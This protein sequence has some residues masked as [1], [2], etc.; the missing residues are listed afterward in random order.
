MAAAGGARARARTRREPRERPAAASTE[1][2]ERGAPTDSGRMPPPVVAAE[3][4]MGEEAPVLTA[5]DF[6]SAEAAS[7][8][9]LAILRATWAAEKEPQREGA[10]AAE[11]EP[12]REGAAADTDPAATTASAAPE[13]FLCTCHL[14]TSAT[15]ANAK[16][17]Q[18]SCPMEAHQRATPNPTVD[19]LHAWLLKQRREDKFKSKSTSKDA[20]QGIRVSEIPI[21]DLLQVLDAEVQCGPCRVSIRAAIFALPSAPVGMGAYKLGGEMLPV[22]L[23][24]RLGERRVVVWLG[25]PPA[26]AFVV[27]TSVPPSALA[28]REL[29]VLGGST[30]APDVFAPVEF[31]LSAKAQEDFR[32]HVPMV[33]P[34]ELLA[35]LGNT[36]GKQPTLSDHALRAVG[37][38]LEALDKLMARTQEGADA[39]ERVRVRVEGLVRACAAAERG[40]DVLRVGSYVCML[41]GVQSGSGRPAV[42]F[43]VA[44]A[45]ATRALDAS[46]TLLGVV[47]EEL[48]AYAL[49]AM[50]FEAR[51]TADEAASF[52][53]AGLSWRLSKWRHAALNVRAVAA[54]AREALGVCRDVLSQPE[55]RALYE[56]GEPFASSVR[57]SICSKSVAE[58]GAAD[59]KQLKCPGGKLPGVE[60]VF[61]EFYAP[62]DDDHVKAGNKTSVLRLFGGLGDDGRTFHPALSPMEALTTLMETG[63]VL[64]IGVASRI[65]KTDELTESGFRPLGKAEGGV[66][67]EAWYGHKQFTTIKAFK[68]AVERGAEVF[69]ERAKGARGAGASPGS[70]WLPSSPNEKLA[71]AVG[72]LSM[73]NVDRC[74]QHFWEWHVSKQRLDDLAAV[75]VSLN[76]D[77]EAL[78]MIV[79]SVRAAMGY[80]PL[81]WLLG[82][83]WRIGR[84]PECS[85]DPRP[86]AK[87][88]AAVRAGLPKSFASTAVWSNAGDSAG[89]VF[90]HVLRP[91]VARE[92]KKEEEAKRA[93]EAEEM[94]Q[95]SRVALEHQRALD[96]AQRAEEQQQRER[97]RKRKEEQ[98]KV[99]VEKARKEKEVREAN[100]ARKRAEEQAREEQERRKAAEERA[101]REEVERAQ[102]E[103][104]EQLR[105]QKEE[106]ARKDREERAAA[107]AARKKEAAASRGSGGGGT[108]KIKREIQLPGG[109]E[110][111][112]R[113]KGPRGE[114]VQRLETLVGASVSFEVHPKTNELSATLTGLED[115]VEAAERV[116]RR[117]SSMRKSVRPDELLPYVQDA[118]MGTALEETV[119]AASAA[120][121]ARAAAKR[122]ATAGRAFAEPVIEA[123]VPPPS[124]YDYEYAYEDEDVSV[125]DGVRGLSNARGENSCFLNVV[126]QSL[127]HIP[128]FS[129]RFTAEA[130]T[131]HVCLPRGPDAVAAIEAR[132]DLSEVQKAVAKR[133]AEAPC[134]TCTVTNTFQA[135][136][137]EGNAAVVSSVGLRAAVAAAFNGAFEMGQM[138]DAAEAFK[139]LLE[140]V[141]EELMLT[142][143]EGAEGVAL[144]R[145]VGKGTGAEGEHVLEDEPDVRCTCSVHAGLSSV[146]LKGARCYSCMALLEAYPW[147]A[148]TKPAK[149]PKFFPV[150]DAATVEAYR[151]VA[152]RHGIVQIRPRWTEL[153]RYVFAVEMNT[154]HGAEFQ[155]RVRRCSAV[156]P[157]SCP[158][159]DEAGFEVEVVLT[160][161]PDVMVLG[162]VWPSNRPNLDLEVR[163]FV[164][165]VSTRINLAHVAMIR[166]DTDTREAPPLCDVLMADLVG[167]ITF[168]HEHYI[169]FARRDGTTNSWLEFNDAS[170]RNVGSWGDV[171]RRM[172]SVPHGLQPVVLLYETASASASASGASG[173]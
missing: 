154:M 75:R 169:A 165:S 66:V 94:A 41:T 131:R 104:A 64:A 148:A 158:L 38:H 33:F 151:T 42:D 171:K 95:Q 45:T 129:R 70:V 17:T 111:S 54:A 3:G 26:A 86:G 6:A 36:S 46:A 173:A 139:E 58:L 128:S 132:T 79:P 116:L 49:Q 56:M 107:E 133:R 2:S 124:A 106:Q 67:G 82:L 112:G 135:L 120:A 118:V 126:T 48:K 119:A 172:C 130:K 102:R 138:E 51:E 168:W 59:T 144:V 152:R 143:G 72:L 44:A 32:A 1:A 141:H 153:M 145:G 142:R 39:S 162:V 7:A 20:K 113:L 149:V 73:E 69:A 78:D 125:V 127:Y 14:N 101:K 89:A 83:K 155:E 5:G 108:V 60:S 85:V 91:L 30:L 77:A 103:V 65:K 99:E 18:P 16:Q 92:W 147:T 109:R 156:E 115:C 81:G 74:V 11:K 37:N 90:S 161:V 12:Q 47:V 160:R 163:P 24:P 8:F 150:N 167:I 87:S 166:L 71:A 34:P 23:V 137:G 61:R 15:P 55:G 52:A 84:R 105:L 80:G 121:A 10:A 9:S 76:A 22:F 122:N 50:R 63:E 117:L 19:E 123:Y 159:C 53:F 164:E 170:V 40:L 27:S 31:P 110:A 29:H 21:P 97:E 157:M 93:A 57:D 68:E 114:L 88:S 98:T 13:P 28:L 100:E 96:E 35:R 136:S 25:L 140:K 134:L 62:P 43:S 4:V 146:C